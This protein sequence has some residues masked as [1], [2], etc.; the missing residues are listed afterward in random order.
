MTHSR[1]RIQ[2]MHQYSQVV[3]HIIAQKVC[4]ERTRR[5]TK[6]NKT[7]SRKRTCFYFSPLFYDTTEERESCERE[8]EREREKRYSAQKEV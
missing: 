3:T 2:Q 8:R 6:R 1:I 4:R 5:D 7:F